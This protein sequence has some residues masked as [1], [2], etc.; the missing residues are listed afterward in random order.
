MKKLFFLTLIIHVQFLAAQTITCQDTVIPAPDTIQGQLWVGA[1]KT[2]YA[3]NESITV[4]IM[5]NVSGPASYTIQEDRLTPTLFS[6]TVNL[7]AN[8]E[9][10]VTAQLNHPG[11]LLIIVTQGN[12]TVRAGVAIEPCNIQPTSYLPSDFDQFWDSLKTE[13]ANIPINPQLTLDSAKSSVAQKTY[14]MILDNIE[15][16]KVYGWISVPNCPG[17]FSAILILPFW[18]YYAVLP[19]SYDR[20]PGAINVFISVHDYDCELVVPSTIGYMPPTH[21]YDKHTNYYKA[22]ILGC[23]RAIDYI[24]SRPDF[25]GVNMALS[26]VSQG[27]GL[28]LITAG[29][30][31]RVKF[32]AQGVTALSDHPGILQ[33]RS[34][35]FPNWVKSTQVAGDNVNQTVEQTGYYDVVNFARKYKGPSLNFVGYNDT[36]CPPSSVFAAYNVLTGKKSMLHGIT[37]MHNNHPD[38]KDER[39]AFFHSHMPFSDYWAG[40]PVNLPDTI[41]PDSTMTLAIDTVGTNNILINWI[42]PGDD[43][44]IGTAYSYDIRYS[45]NPIDSANFNSATVANVTTYPFTSGSAQ[46]FNLTGLTAGTLYYIALKTIDEANNVST[47]SNIVSGTT[48]LATGIGEST[49]SNFKIFPNP[50][51]QFLNIENIQDANEIEIINLLGEK[52]QIRTITTSDIKIDISWLKEGIYILSIKSKNGTVRNKVFVKQN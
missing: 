27:G 48:L 26:G 22:S 51:N 44:D 47:I 37:T 30:D 10:Q 50:A 32:V 7:V 15:G 36:L 4:R 20:I 2:L 3:V 1:N 40:C 49:L 46:S 43:I 33:D 31:K 17:P 9:T 28:S 45:T 19:T 41:A 25:D 34:S 29:L 6:G 13:L 38:F 11:F 42:S 21:F 5:S 24:F 12:N 18:G 35:G 14:K 16:K 8:V 23:I 39:I 52:L